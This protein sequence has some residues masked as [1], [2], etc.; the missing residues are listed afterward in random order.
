MIDFFLENIR[1]C[2]KSKKVKKA[3][4]F[5]YQIWYITSAQRKES[6]KQKLNDLWKL[7]K[8]VNLSSLGQT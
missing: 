7:S 8:K 3:V 5:K 4:D 6:A 2:K 1:K